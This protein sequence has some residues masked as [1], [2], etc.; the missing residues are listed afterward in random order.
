M[1]RRILCYAGWVEN[2][3]A[4]T[5]KFYTRP[6]E[7]RN[8][9]G[10]SVVENVTLTQFGSHARW[11]CLLF[12]KTVC[13]CVWNCGTLDCVRNAKLNLRGEFLYISP[14]IMRLADGA[15]ATKLGGASRMWP[16]ANVGVC[17]VAGSMCLESSGGKKKTI[18]LYTIGCLL[19]ERI[20]HSVW[21][22]NICVER[23]CQLISQF[24]IVL[25]LSLFQEFI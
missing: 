15:F 19:N 18:N 10:S 2:R 21:E 23:V 8:L 25:S 17:C 9:T 11:V 1:I 3:T 24:N 14:E 6:H 16:T 5:Y 22:Q 13:R 4:Q 12:T 7:L 20:T